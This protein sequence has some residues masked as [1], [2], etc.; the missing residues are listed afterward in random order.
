M[1]DVWS[2]VHAERAA[3]IDDLER[4]DTGSWEVPSLCPGWTVHDVVAHLVDTAR[5]TRLGFVV[6]LARAGFDF[7]R[8][9]ARGVERER[10]SSPQETLERLRRVASRTSTPPAPLD[11]RLVE[12]VVH[13]E[14]IRRPLGL[15]RSYPEEAVVRALRLQAR[16]PA[17]FGGAKELVA[18][19]R[20]TATDADVSIGNGPE[21]T[22][23][24]LSLL[25][26]VSGRQV[27][28]DDLAGPGVDALR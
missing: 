7:D 4:L 9:N 18:R 2:L 25:L 23:T 10:A 8:Q 28:V 16:T 21:L 22:G 6:G 12:E 24:A 20:L 26:A 15:T 1:G 13:G 5:T 11:T 17:S 19:V 27:A 14:D 3:L